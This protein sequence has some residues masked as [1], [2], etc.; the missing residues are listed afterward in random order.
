MKKSIIAV[1]SI[2]LLLL[3]ACGNGAAKTLE[4]EEAESTNTSEN[5]ISESAEKVEYKN[6]YAPSIKVSL[7]ENTVIDITKSPKDVIKTVCNNG[8]SI[9]D[10]RFNESYR[11]DEEGEIVVDNITTDSDTSSF[12]VY[13]SKVVPAEETS[14]ACCI[15][16]L[17]E[18]DEFQCDSISLFA[19]WN[20]LMTELGNYLNAD[21]SITLFGGEDK[22]LSAV[23]KDGE[24]V[25]LK[26]IYDEYGTEAAKVSEYD[27][28]KKYYE[29]QG[30]DM[31]TILS[32]NGIFNAFTLY[33]GDDSERDIRNAIYCALYDW[34]EKYSRGKIKNYGFVMWSEKGRV[35]HVFEACPADEFLEFENAEAR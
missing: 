13:M 9:I 31:A 5:P 20:G 19:D 33:N 28:L 12:K 29:A 2:S 30:Q 6:P 3:T 1:F 4:V 27:S 7:N 8:G 15:H 16:Y 25:S 11:I 22:R 34:G 24:I 18:D 14:K 21:N 35:L 23:Y 17:F 10:K 26:E 32:D